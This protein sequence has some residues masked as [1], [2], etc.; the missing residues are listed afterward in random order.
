MKIGIFTPIHKANS[1]HFKFLCESIAKQTRKPDCWAIVANGELNNQKGLE[2]ILSIIKDFPEIDFVMLTKSDSSSIGELKGKAC[3]VLLNM[4]CDLLVEVDYD[5]YLRFDAILQLEA[6]VQNSSASFF[7][8]DFAHF[9]FTELGVTSLHYDSG[10]GWKSSL[11]MEE[12]ICSYPLNA[13]HAFPATPQYLA[14][15]E[16]SPNHLRAF[17][18]KGYKEVGGYNPL[19]EV[20]DD[21]ELICR[22]FM[23][24][25][26]SGFH[27]I[28][29]CL[30]FQRTGGTTT[31]KKNAEIQAQVFRNYCKYMEPMFK[32]WA[33]ER[34]LIQVDLGG[35]FNS[36]EGYL[37]VDLL[38]A[39]LVF[40]LN[41]KWELP[42]NGVG[43]IR[44]YHVIEHL[45]DPIHF[46]N[47]AYRVLAPGGL[48]LIEVPSIN[49]PSAF[50][51]PTH[52]TF[53]STENFRYY[54]DEQKARFIRPQYK[55]AFLPLRVEEYNW[56]DGTIVV[57]AQ[58]LAL[59]GKYNNS[60]WG[61]KKTDEKYIQ[62]GY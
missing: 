62:H 42:T 26:A 49:H 36:P 7:Y 40:D 15:I 54:T 60:W 59:K 44:A 51:D 9:E 11:I 48:L 53:W 57:T 39:D 4:D 34:A 12:A 29:E 23:Q 10:Y 32:L 17:T 13:M 24:Y 52:K 56:S 47:E 50:A 5:D 25:G 27:H 61:N 35:R 30:Y 37:S 21:H 14:R 41:K 58:L 46:F 55:G 31:N 19:L 3:N 8:S 2:W 18:A 43:V 6:V 45:D 22:F 33:G 16:S 20:G 1:E 38:D 28:K